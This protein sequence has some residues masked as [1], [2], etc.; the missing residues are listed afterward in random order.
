MMRA[1]IN[2]EIYNLV[3][4]LGSKEFLAL[5]SNIICQK[6]ITRELQKKITFWILNS[7][8]SLMYQESEHA[9][10]CSVKYMQRYQKKKP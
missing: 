2:L 8:S 10:S 3:P 6:A 9:V 7:L 4:R 1:L 5:L